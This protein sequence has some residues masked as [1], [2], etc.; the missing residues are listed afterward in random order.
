MSQAEDRLARALT[1][2][3][4]IERE[5]GAGG[6]A[7][8]YLA[9]DLKHH[10][11]VAVKVLRPELSAILGAERFLNEIEVTANLQ[12]PNILPLYD[13]GEADGLLYYVMPYV[14]GETLREKL[15]REKQLTV[16][17]TVEIAKG[18]AAALEFAHR[19][20]VV[21]RDIKPANILLQ[22]GQPLVADFGIALAVSHAGGTRLTETG[23][24]LGTP[25]YMSPEQAT[26][27]RE[28]DAR[29]DIYSLGAM[30]YEMLVGEPPHVGRSVQA[31]VAKIL[32]DDPA[33][34]TRSRQLVPPNV[35]AA[36]RRALA[37]SPA[38]RFA[39]AADFA[40][41]LTNPSFTLATTTGLAVAGRG[42]RIWKPIGIAAL[43]LAVLAIV[44][45]VAG[46]LRSPGEAETLVVRFEI[47]LDEALGEPRFGAV[48]PDGSN[49]VL[50]LGEFRRARLY[51]RSLGDVSA[52]AVVPDQASADWPFFSSDG[53]RV[54]FVTDDGEL[55]VVPLDG[56]PGRTLADSVIFASGWGDDGYVYFSQGPGRPKLAR[57][58]QSGGATE[59]LLASDSVGMVAPHPL[60][61][62]RALLFAT[63]TNP[64]ATP[65]VSIMDLRSG[66]WRSL[67]EG[68]P[69]VVYAP[70]G[71]LLFSRDRFLMAAPFDLGDLQLT[72]EPVP[73]AEV[74]RGE[75]G[76]FALGGN[77]LVYQGLPGGSGN[78]PVL[79]DR[80]G[81]RRKLENVPDAHVFGYP[82]ASPDGRKIALRVNPLG[83]D[84]NAMDVWIYELP[85]G[86]L[87]RL[88][89]EGR[90][91]DPS[92]TP[93]G[94]RVLFNSDR[95]GT[96]AL[97]WKPW[98]GSGPAEMVLD[99]EGRLW[100][101]SWL[102]DGRR[103]VFYEADSDGGEDVG[104]A[105]IGEPDS[106]RMLLTG[107]YNESWPVVS[108][109]GRWLAYES[110][111]SGR[112]EVY[113][114]PLAGAGT[115]RQIS[116]R[117]GTSPEWAYSGRELFFL[118]ED[119]LYS[120]RI[121]AGEDI[122]VGGVQALFAT[123]CCGGGY[124]VLPGDSLFVMFQNAGMG[125][126]DQ[127][128]IVVHNFL[129]ELEERMSA[130]GRR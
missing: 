85:T 129:A 8:V 124:D 2:R 28:L 60:P 100:R 14:E 23:L 17:E 101:S 20:G 51:L 79:V 110:N 11:K 61:G 50:S 4:R 10:R 97:Y 5:L 102:P 112:D 108:P 32:T 128:V 126:S 58:Q 43:G 86:P 75:F 122:R 19:R 130:A 7:T 48:S 84:E 30:V 87:T 46:W 40:D 27:D 94:R 106:T 34:I 103:F 55:Q 111:E 31:I 52:R 12:H 24:S 113:V 71:H 18:V 90:D 68:G 16:E 3:Y 45:G 57:V 72:G 77:T 33:P 44:V 35:D 13:S 121:E 114:R 29:S 39:T 81:I 104:L 109:D 117:G 127:P 70:T 6:M 54:G 22:A 120:A 107:R 83:S 15:D 65:R 91:D 1:D 66:E 9:E 82:A 98:D 62:G 92:W 76:W 56:G 63:F 118:T 53:R 25:H 93:D 69:V 21:H 105:M 38:D 95:K 115:R 80:A 67:T 36:V 88:T 74:P 49:I 42:S 89:F 123:P 37:K 64:E 116:R 99:R 26:G 59:I 73:V 119:S 125:E 47:P 96:G 41:A 78:E